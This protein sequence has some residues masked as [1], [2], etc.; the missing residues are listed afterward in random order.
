MT[1]PRARK[2]WRAAA[3]GLAF[4]LAAGPMT[5]GEAPPVPEGVIVVRSHHDVATTLDRLER[6]LEAKGITVAL[7]WDHAARARGAGLALRPTAL[8]VFGNPRLGTRIMQGAQTAG[9]DMPLRALAWEDAE[10]RVW[11]GVTDPVWIARRHG[12]GEVPVAARMRAAVTGFIREAAAP[13][14]R[15]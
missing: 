6:I 12:A 1:G 4:G 15:R 5:A 2:G 14:G 8:L 7:R 9:I 11:L 3:A 13:A 10:G